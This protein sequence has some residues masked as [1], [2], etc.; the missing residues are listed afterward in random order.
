MVGCD[1]DSLM[2][3]YARKSAKT[4]KLPITYIEGK[5]EKLPFK[6]GYFDAVI[7]G[8][9]FH[10]FAT[11]KAFSQISRV[12][13]PG[14]VFMAFWKG[15][16]IIKHN[17]KIVEQDIYE[18]YRC[19]SVTKMWRNIDN[20]KRLFNS[21]GF[22]HFQSFKLYQKQRDTVD[23]L[24]GG[25]RTLSKYAMLSASDKRKFLSELRVA[26]KAALGHK[27]YFVSKRENIGCRA[28]K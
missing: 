22:K 20:T 17:G 26:Y 8:T 3:K 13:K 15:P 25:Q 9:S 21:A 27:K 6:S 1:H 7:A 12:M 4:K 11:R 16:T 14:A 2:L 23:E 19:T 18:R 28:F 24:L 5:A 10:W